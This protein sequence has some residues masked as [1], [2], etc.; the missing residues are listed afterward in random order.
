MASFNEISALRYQTIISESIRIELL[1][2]QCEMG[3]RDGNPGRILKKKTHKSNKPK[4]EAI[5]HSLQALER[6]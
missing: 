2:L 5:S 3:K 6:C 4:R 1:S